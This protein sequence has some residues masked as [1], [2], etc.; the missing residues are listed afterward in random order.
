MSELIIRS[1]EPRDVPELLGMVKEL[2]TYERMADRVTATEADYH[3]ALFGPDAHAQAAIAE[4]D[5]DGVVGYMVWF[6]SFSTF[7]ARAKLHL[8]DLY[9]RE[10][11]RGRGYGKALLAD[12]AARAVAS[13]LARV[14]WQ[15]LDWN[16]P[17]IDFYRGLGAEVSREWLWCTLT[18]PPLD[19]LALPSR[20]KAK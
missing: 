3:I 18:G 7:S 6:R 8:E 4:T 13:G 12:L 2:A 10:P 5:D 16:Q 1:A 11:F 15:V 9:V 14:H 19:G 17:S 20:N